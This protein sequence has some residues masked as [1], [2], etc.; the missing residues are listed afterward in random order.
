MIRQ[1]II[2]A[3]TLSTIALPAVAAADPVI[4]QPAPCVK[5]ADLAG[6]DFSVKQC[7]ISDVDQYRAG[8]ENN[9]GSYCGP[10]SLYNVLHHWAHERNAPVGWLTTKVKNLDPK[11]PADHN[12]ITNSVGR[13][14]VDAQYTSK[15]TKLSNLRTAWTIATKPAR[16]A[17]WSTATEG[18][19]PHGNADFGGDMAK[20]L[21]RG[22]LQMLYGR[23]T[24]GPQSSLQRGGG[25]L[26]TV[27]AVEGSFGG[28]TVQVRYMD[29]AKAADHG[30]GDYLKTQSTYATVTATLTK[31]SVYEYIPV[32]DNPDTDTDESLTPGTYR[33]VTRWQLTTPT[34]TPTTT[35][36]V[37]GFNWFDMAPPVG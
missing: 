4:G 14:G 22:P 30:V 10:S 9:G 26:V 6:A 5:I 17:G 2:A 8:L 13:I 32:T 16:D 11:D 12:V 33:T 21:A 19:S 27:T 24:A 1:A 3:A 29:P 20:K 18:I 37:E 31:R 36:L 15:G 28:N 35:V 23:Y 25:H 7:G 34:S